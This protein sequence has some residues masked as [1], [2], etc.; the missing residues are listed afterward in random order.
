[1]VETEKQRLSRIKYRNKPEVKKR[2]LENGRSKYHKDMNDPVKRKEKSDKAKLYRSN[3]P[4]Y[5]KR[6]RYEWYY[7]NQEFKKQYR[8]DRSRN[9]MIQVLH[10]YSKGRI[11]C[12]CCGEK[13]IGFLTIDHVNGGGNKHRRELG[14]RNIAGVNFYE[15]LKRNK[16][17]DGYQV[18]CFNCNCG[19][20]RVGGECPHKTVLKE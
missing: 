4:E 16:F 7:K 18:M 13:I 17:P 15:W 5:F 6:K 19:R 20:S 2:M 11:E 12:I 14:M 8:K 10:H 1:M 9:I 3:N